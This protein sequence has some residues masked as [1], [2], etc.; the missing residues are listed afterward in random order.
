[1]KKNLEIKKLGEV[2][3]FEGGSQ[4]PKSNFIYEPKEGYVRFLQIRDFASDKYITYIP[5]SKKNRHCDV[6]DILLGRYG[7]SVGKILI[8]KKGAYNVAVMKTIPNTELIDKNYFYYYLISDEFQRPL[9]KVAS[10]SAQAGFSKDDIYNFPVL[11]P[12]LLEQNKIVKILD[13]SLNKIAKAKENAEKNLQ[14]SKEL[15]E[16]YIEEAF[17]DQSEIC[18]F[19]DVINL[20]T[21]Y[22]ANGSYKVLKANVSLKNTEDYAWMIRST[23]FENSFQNEKRYITKNAYEFMKKSKVFGNELIISKIGNAGKVYLM[24]EINRPCSLAMNLFL[25]RINEE[26]CLSGYVY[27]YL[28]SKEGKQQIESRTFGATTKTITKENVRS[29]K[30][31]KPTLAEQREI[32]RKHDTFSEQTKKLEANYKQKIADLDELRKSLLTKAFAG[33]L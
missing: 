14:N 25:I 5:D 26:K 11:T 24:P 23:D 29:I 12:S 7:A 16:S 18:E 15:L 20:L 30:I 10:R 21:D 33:E 17:N 32:I 6:G 13:E 22:H 2:C 27:R 31:P 1:M 3:N 9:S 19:G 28:N 4:P 8:N